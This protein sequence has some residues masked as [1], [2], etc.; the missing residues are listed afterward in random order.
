MGASLETAQD[1]WDRLIDGKVVQPRLYDQDLADGLRAEFGI[2]GDFRSGLTEVS[3]QRLIEAVFRGL[4]PVAAMVADLLRLYEVISAKRASDPNLRMRFNFDSDEQ[5]IDLNLAT[6]R[7]WE[8]RLRSTLVTRRFWSWKQDPAWALVATIDGALPRYEQS[9]GPRPQG[10]RSVAWPIPGEPAPVSG[11]EELDRRIAAVW[12]ARETF[13]AE[14][15][16]QWPAR[17]DYRLA[18]G[19]MAGSI[20]EGA[21]MV[22]DFWDDSLA[23]ALRQL[24]IRGSLAHREL[25]TESLSTTMA[26]LVPEIDAALDRLPSEKRQITEAVTELESILSLPMWGKRHELYAA[27]VFTQIA[28]AIGHTRLSFVVESGHFSF[29]FRGSK[30]ATFDTEQG[31]VELWAELR[32]AY[33]RPVG[34]GRTKSIQPDFR[35]V[36]LPVED[37]EST[38]L[39]VEVK[40]YARS[41]L[42]N[43]ADALADYTGGLPRAHVVLAAHGPVSSKVLEGLT[44][45]ARARAHVVRDLH[46]GNKVEIAT[47][48]DLVARHVPPLPSPIAHLIP[49][50]P[51]NV[52]DRDGDVRVALYWD[53][54][55]V[56][57][58]LHAKLEDGQTVSYAGLRATTSNAVVRLERDVQDAP[59]PEVL[60]IVGT[61]RVVV[62]VH[63]YTDRPLSSVGARLHVQAGSNKLTMTLG[64]TPP[65][66]GGRWFR[67]L[68]I[69]P[70]RIETVEEFTDGSALD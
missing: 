18:F 1:V 51:A 9:D 5:P 31:V 3:A 43:A 24:A 47:F 54:Q 26:S 67:A 66:K 22:S 41:F 13:V 39:A 30:L 32:T 4:A 58:D 28:E 60:H 10:E 8:A 6:F 7:E 55:G 48:C 35:L 12:G 50:Q 49:A 14:M 38:L 40:Q 11:V 56:D 44:P 61:D 29:D 27:W 36:T 62:A 70:D 37:P 20:D 25:D 21:L 16:K 42:R 2:R 57:L 64:P 33:D 45:K 52:L 65:G 69:F 19:A 59:G 46:P 63:S 34:H 53:E 23:E 17:E 68:V 15:S